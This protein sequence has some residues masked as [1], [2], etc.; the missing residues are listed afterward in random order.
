MYSADHKKNTNIS[1]FF[2]DRFSQYIIERIGKSYGTWMQLEIV[3]QWFTRIPQ[4]AGAVA[5]N[6]VWIATEHGSKSFCF[7]LPTHTGN[8]LLK[9]GFNVQSQIEIRVRKLKNPIC[10]PGGHFESDTAENQQAASHIYTQ[11][12]CY[13]SLELI[14]KAKMKLESGNWK[15]QYGCQEAILQVICYWSL[16]LIFK[17]RN[18]KIH[19]ESDISDNN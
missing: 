10:L 11:V 9:F 16:H 3:D 13:W 7:Y 17:A 8:M 14:F 6:N 2:H 1:S 5:G 4:T 18:W 15:I 12:I 19:F